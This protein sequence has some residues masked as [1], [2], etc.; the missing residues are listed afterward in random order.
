MKE[1]EYLNKNQKYLYLKVFGG[2][3]G[4]LL[5]VLSLYMSLAKKP[6]TEDFELLL[7]INSIIGVVGII[8]R[9]IAAIF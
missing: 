5:M 9:I 2:I 7:T 6:I 3:L 8:Y 1:E 4:L